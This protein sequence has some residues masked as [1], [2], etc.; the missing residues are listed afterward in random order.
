MTNPFDDAALNFEVLGN[1]LG[2]RSLW[3]AGIAIPPGWE[4]LH[5]P[6][7]RADAVRWV[8]RD[9]LQADAQ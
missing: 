2:Q 7:S 3:P 1:T 8:D 9:A 6:T 4:R 5:G